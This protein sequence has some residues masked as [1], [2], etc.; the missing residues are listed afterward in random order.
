MISVKNKYK[1]KK[2]YNQFK[3]S[4]NSSNIANVKNNSNLEIKSFLDLYDENINEYFDRLDNYDGFFSTQ[5]IESINFENFEEHVFFDSAIEKTNYSFKK[6]FNDF[7]YDGSEREVTNYLNGLDGYTRFILKNKH[8]KNLGYLKFDNN[9]YIKVVDRNGWLLNDF[10]KNIKIGLLNLTNNFNFS[11]D[12]WLYP[13]TPVDS[14]NQQIIFQKVLNNSGFSI[15]LSNFSSSNC[16]LNFFISKDDLEYKCTTSVDINKWSHINISLNSVLVNDSNILRCQ[17]YINSMPKNAVHSNTGWGLTFEED[18]NNVD[19]T[20]GGGNELHKSEIQSNEKSYYGLLDE[21]RVYA[22]EVRDREII[23]LEKDENVFSK[24]SLKLYFRFNEPSGDYTNNNIVLDHSGN[25]LH[26]LI[27]KT[28]NNL[29]EDDKTI[30]TSLRLKH[31]DVNTPLIYELLENNPVLFPK[32]SPAIDV[33]NAIIEEAKNYD[34]NNPNSFWKLLPKNIFIEG[35]DFDNVDETYVNSDKFTAK[36]TLIGIRTAP[37][38]KMINLLSIWARF[39][40]EFK[41]YIDSITSIIDMNYDNLNNGKLVDGVLLPLAL[42]LSGFN[43]REILPYP[44]LEK[45]KNKNLTSEEKISSLSIRQV[46]NKLWQRLLINSKDILISKGTASS[47]HSV[48]NSFGLESSKFISVKE[49]NGQNKFNINNDFYSKK[50]S[51][52]EIDFSCDK[53]LFNEARFENRIL[54][55]SPTYSNNLTSNPLDISREWTVE[56]LYSYKS[57]KTEIYPLKQSLL[58]L[59]NNT[60]SSEVL[61]FKVPHINIVFERENKKNKYGKIKLFVNENSIEIGEIN[62][63]NLLSGELFYLS[64]QRKKNENIDSNLTYYEY[65][66]T[67]SSVSENFYSKKVQQVKIETKADIFYKTIRPNI[68]SIGFYDAYDISSNPDFMPNMSYETKFEGS[69]SNFR[70]YKK[71]MSDQEIFLKCKTI[72]TV[73]L[74][75]GIESA[76]LNI[77]LFEKLSNISLAGSIYEIKSLLDLSHS[78]LNGF[79]KATLLPGSSLITSSPAYFP[80]KSRKIQGLIQN[81]EIDFPKS[82]NFIYI[83]SFESEK[84][85][86]QYGNDNIANINQVR[87]D[88]LYSDDT[89]L[90]IDFSSVNFL[91]QDITKIININKVFTEK[92]SQSSNLFTDSYVDLN[93][94]RDKYFERLEKEI[95]INDLYQVYKYFDNILE[96]LLYECVPSKVKYKGFNFVYESHA[97]ERHKYQYKMINSNIPVFDE[98][99]KHSYHRNLSNSIDHRKTE[100]KNFSFVDSNKVSR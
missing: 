13:F 83:N 66:L 41:M 78:K 8:I 4:I 10:K 39:F 94:L 96:E 70:I 51:L 67:V 29:P 82:N 19:I 72:S 57:D 5:Q 44:I 43:F 46:Q 91:N 30:I 12:F 18:F 25:K 53:E 65:I 88:Y 20:I 9:H 15:F 84:F 52:K 95:N 21:F 71:S 50:I 92:L 80:F 76:I 35:S 90:S 6:I 99:L 16:D 32:Y 1:N 17:Y 24:E 75:D 58:R 89:R 73:A 36:D 79:N 64:L 98:T 55:K 48:F 49:F 37:N 100:D 2:V 81:S 40:D 22:G 26:G 23:A 74:D 54:F 27:Y 97:L 31:L 86:K 42:K 28:A 85:K 77:D 14:S 93:K 87:P 34:L 56:C 33:Q 59:D 63:V 61:S 3:N 68:F 60:R 69:I 45:L 11:F 62:K 47:I 7:P 38:Q